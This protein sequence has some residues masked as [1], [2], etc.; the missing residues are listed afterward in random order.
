MANVTE[1]ELSKLQHEII[2]EGKNGCSFKK[3]Y[4]ESDS[5][6]DSED[7]L[8]MKFVKPKKKGG[9]DF[10]TTAYAFALNNKMSKLK[11]ELARTEERLRYL[12]LDYNNVTIKIEEQ[13]LIIINLKSKY[14]INILE[15]KK[16]INKFTLI[17]FASLTLNGVFFI[18]SVISKLT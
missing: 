12:Q 17:L 18:S 2:Q 13:K 9:N 8:I 1:E 15:N 4:S 7:D 5:E 14:S 11:C 10:E 6:V 3:N 16:K